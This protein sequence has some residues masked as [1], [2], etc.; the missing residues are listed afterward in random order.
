MTFD[1]ATG[2][3]SVYLKRNTTINVTTPSYMGAFAPKL[4]KLFKLTCEQIDKSANPGW[5][6]RYNLY[7]DIPDFIGYNPIG[8]TCLLR[9]D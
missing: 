6:Y 1:P 2:K 8:Q 9:R 7:A 5:F 4:D 3:N